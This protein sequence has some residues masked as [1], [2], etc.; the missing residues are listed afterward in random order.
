MRGRG[1]IYLDPPGAEGQLRHLGL[2]SAPTSYQLSNDAGPRMP[3]LQAGDPLQYSLM[4]LGL[5]TGPSH[6]HVTGNSPTFHGSAGIT[7]I[8]DFA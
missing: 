4:G 7:I 2:I 8:S 5:F 3:W 1:R 6:S